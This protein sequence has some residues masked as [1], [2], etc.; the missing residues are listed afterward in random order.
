MVA[1]TPLH[2]LGKNSRVAKGEN[3][4]SDKDKPLGPKTK[5]WLR[6]GRAIIKLL[7]RVGIIAA[8]K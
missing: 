2:L 5:F 7:V 8:S 6:T 3:A 4:M 1:Q